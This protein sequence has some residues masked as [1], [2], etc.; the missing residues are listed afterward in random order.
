MAIT[1]TQRPVITATVSSLWNAVG[2]PILYKFTRKDYSFNQIN[3]DAGNVQLQFSGVNISSAFTSGQILWLESDAGTYS[4]SAEVISSTYSAPN[5]LVRLDTAYVSNDTGY[6]NNNTTRLNYKLS[7]GVYTSALVGTIRVS[8]DKKGNI[9]ADISKVLWSALSPNID[10]DI[11]T[12]TDV[13]TDSN[14]YKSFYI[15]YNELWIGSSEIETDDSANTFYTVYGARQ[16][17]SLYGGNVIEYAYTNV[18]YAL[19]DTDFT[20]GW[21]NNGNGTVAWTFGL[22]MSVSLGVGQT[23]QRTLRTCSLIGDITYKIKI[24]SNVTTLEAARAELYLSNGQSWGNIGTLSWLSPDLTY[25]FTPTSDVT[26]IELRLQAT[27]GS[28]QVDIQDV[29][30]Y[31]SQK[32]ALTKFSELKMWRDWP[33]LL[34]FILNE[35][36]TSTTLSISPYSSAGASSSSV[37]HFNLNEIITDQTPQ[38]YIAKLVNSTIVTSNPVTINL[39]DACENPI[40][41]I[42]R[43][44]LGGALCWLFDV[45]QEYTFV[46]EDG[47]KRKRLVLI[48]ENLTLNE[49]ESLQDFITLGEVYKDNIVEFTSSV[50]KTSSRIGAQV[51]AVDQDGNKTGVIVIPTENRT[52]TKQERHVFTLEIEY[53]EI[54]TT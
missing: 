17:P 48:A 25:S 28:P 42:G 32:Q 22:N 4:V 53:P 43:N 49:W 13:F 23:S 40:M 33:L 29:E 18:L 39:V 16:I 19:D 1:V 27:T 6:V 35:N 36:D 5:T 15:K 8:P 51:Y 20:T 3:N 31:V 9:T 44:T 52:N 7:I 46:Y 45:S 26:S 41:L 11:T 37:T 47:A 12:N 10:S 38:S 2:N 14:S 50:I 34:S 54:F 21:S 24:N 30:I